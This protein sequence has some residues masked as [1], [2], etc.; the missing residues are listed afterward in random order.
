MDL[1]NCRMVDNAAA[2]CERFLN[3]LDK[4]PYIS[5][6]G[7][8]LRILAAEVQIAAGLVFVAIKAF[9]ALLIGQTWPLKESLEGIIHCGHG[10]LNIVRGSIAIF[11]WAG[12]FILFVYDFY[13]GRM[14][15]KRESLPDNIYP[16]IANFNSLSLSAM[17]G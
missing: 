1:I 13:I 11:P 16:L 6:W 4:I 17:S 8:V 3:P 12:N 9:E 7:G 5:S 14:E 10:V 2:R 15:Y